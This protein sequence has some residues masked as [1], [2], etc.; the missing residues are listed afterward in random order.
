[1]IKVRATKAG[2]IEHYREPGEEFE[3]KDAKAFSKEWMEKIGEE[4]VQPKPQ[5][6]QKPQ[7]KKLD[8]DVI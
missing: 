5:P 6:S 3:I 1:M 4:K 8:E 7:G 2:F